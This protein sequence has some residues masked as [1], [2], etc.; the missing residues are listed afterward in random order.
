M[1]RRWPGVLS[2]SPLDRSA[3]KPTL[4]GN[5]AGA[6]SKRRRSG[7]GRF[8]ETRKGSCRILPPLAHRLAEVM[9]VLAAVVEPTVLAVGRPSTGRST[10]PMP[11]AIRFG[12][13]VVT[14]RRFLMERRCAPMHWDTF[15]NVSRVEG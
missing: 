1:W 14:A 8:D 12:R 10:G 7:R 11:E 15:S 9:S 2:N 6:C 5:G 4:A 3:V 13:H